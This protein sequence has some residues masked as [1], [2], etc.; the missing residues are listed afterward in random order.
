[1]LILL[2]LALQTVLLSAQGNLKETLQHK[3]D[4]FSEK[5]K[6]LKDGG[7]VGVQMS[8]KMKN[9]VALDI[10]GGPTSVSKYFMWGSCTKTWT[11]V[12]V[13][14]MVEKGMFGL[15]DKITDLLNP[16]LLSRNKTTLEEIYHP[17]EWVKNVTVRFIL[18][19]NAGIQDYNEEKLTSDQTENP[20]WDITPIDMLFYANRTLLDKP[21]QTADYSSTDYEIL[22]L[23]LARYTND[24]DWNEYDQKDLY[25]NLQNKEEYEKTYFPSQGTCN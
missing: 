22:G 9:G 16:Y 24:V 1:M 19:M 2:F 25:K 17:S 6:I 18:N 11:A 10:A 20:L 5:Y 23:L 3:L 14:Q 4:V 8:L 12:A 13:L 21:G 7:P 15:D